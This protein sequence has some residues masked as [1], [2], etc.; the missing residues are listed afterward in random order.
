MPAVMP[1]I[2]APTTTARSGGYSSI[3]CSSRSKGGQTVLVDGCELPSVGPKGLSDCD[4]LT[5]AMVQCLSASCVGGDATKFDITRTWRYQDCKTRVI[6]GTLNRGFSNHAW[7]CNALWGSGLIV[8]MS[9]HTIGRRAC[10]IHRDRYQRCT[11]ITVG[12]KA[13]LPGVTSIARHCGSH[14]CS[15]RYRSFVPS[16][17]LDCQG[18]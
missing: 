8:Q 13:G 18:T 1:L 7:P 11:D 9:K 15:F 12:N 10:I 3:G 5:G 16:G 17:L 6:K 14:Y 2:P 4:G